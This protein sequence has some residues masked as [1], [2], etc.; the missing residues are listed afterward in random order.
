MNRFAQP[1]QIL[2]QIIMVFVIV[3][4]IS[5]FIPYLPIPEKYINFFPVLAIASVI[6][7]FLFENKNGGTLGFKDTHAV[8]RTSLGFLYGVIT[9]TS[10]FLLIWATKG[11]RIVNIDLQA[12]TWTQ[13]ALF[14]F[15]FFIVSIQEELLTRG[16]LYGVFRRHYSALTTIL[17]TSIIFSLLHF[18]NPGVLTSPIPFL[19]IL[20][21]GIAL[22]L[23][24]EYSGS[25]WLAVGFHW[26]WNLLQ[27]NVFGFPVSGIPPTQPFI[28]SQ[29]QNN[30]ILS[31]G[32]F[33]AE[34]SIFANIVLLLFIGYL[35]RR[36]RRQNA[37]L[38]R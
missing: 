33:G 6:L 35:Y 13:F 3:L 4:F 31:G 26:S 22:G 29:V 14:V 11:L 15:L 7:F 19:S 17:F 12:N 21:A 30:P 34:G 38:P 36:S 10:V 28:D 25:I 18:L 24:R 8:K 20:L 16:Y 32:G 1:L 37:D 5:L 23:L 9:I 27:G 2:L